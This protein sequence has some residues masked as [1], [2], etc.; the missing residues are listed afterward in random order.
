MTKSNLNSLQGTN[1][2]PFSKSFKVLGLP[3]Y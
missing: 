3:E 2:S 1:Q